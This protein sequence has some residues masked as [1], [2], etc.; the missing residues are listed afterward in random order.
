MLWSVRL[1]DLVQALNTVH[2]GVLGKFFVWLALVGSFRNV[3]SA[4]TAKDDNIEQRVGAKS[5]RSVY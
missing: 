4:C 1:S 5:V 3:V 2:A